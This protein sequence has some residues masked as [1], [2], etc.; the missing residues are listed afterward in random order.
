MT[1]DFGLRQRCV[2]GSS[3]CTSTGC[4]VAAFFSRVSVV[5]VRNEAGA[6]GTDVAVPLYVDANDSIRQEI[7]IEKDLFGLLGGRETYVVDSSGTVKSVFNSQ[8]DPEAHVQTA[9]AAV[10]TLPKSPIDEL[11]K[12]A[13]EFASSLGIEL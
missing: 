9:K 5:G 8:F 4:W 11:K 1:V 7:G 13:A 10:A 12:S 2:L 6:K 3:F